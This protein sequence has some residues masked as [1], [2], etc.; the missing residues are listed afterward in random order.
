MPNGKVFLRETTGLLREF[1]YLDALWINLS[2]G[3]VLFTV[4]YVTSTAPLIGG[5]PIIG[6]L[7]TFIGMIPIVLAFSI[8]AMIT[9][10]TAG[11]YVF[12]TRFFSPALGFIGNASYLVTTVP[13][14]MGVT[15]VTLVSFGFAPLFTYWG[16][17]L[18]NSMFTQ[19][20]N[21]IQSPYIT[22]LIGGGLTALVGSLP[23]FGYKVFKL[24]NSLVIPLVLIASVIILILLVLTP[25]T[26]ALSAL[27]QFANN[28]TLVQAINVW[29]ASYNSPPPSITSF[30]NTLALNPLYIVGLSYVFSVIYIAGEVRQVNKNIPLAMLTTLAIYTFILIASTALSYHTFSYTFLSN[31]YTLS[32]DYGR[33]PF[34]VIPYLTFL[35][36]IISRNI[37]ISSFIFIVVIIQLLWYQMS[38]VFLGSR[39]LISY[40]LDRIL[41]N[42]FADI[43][44]RFHTPIKAIIV[45]IILTLIGAVFF[46]LPV[47]AGIALLLS[48][49]GIALIL[50]FPITIVGFSLLFY[51][52]KRREEFEKSIVRNSIFGG[53]AYYVIAIGTIVYSLFVFS[54]Y[55]TVPAIFG[56]AGMM[57][58]DLIIIPPIILFTLY[59]ITKYIN[60]KRGVP[61]DLIFKQIPPE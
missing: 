56:Y 23:I 57:G 34:P 25:R 24:A 55:I 47:T 7:I 2:I 60:I 12:T 40:S 29:G 8:I 41:P 17:V 16:V 9:P 21:S 5:D 33:S 13:I 45:T 39:L 28:V 61:V 35:A 44:E 15:V 18:H 14:Y 52:I 1:G 31:L 27:N 53:R 26:S 42:F 50:I 59:Y 51:R 11:D 22:L 19:L 48:A 20:A 49:A 4:N 38:G 32:I 58:I 30:I 10:R 3:G 6:G 37:Y 36:A 46:V 43:N 54:E